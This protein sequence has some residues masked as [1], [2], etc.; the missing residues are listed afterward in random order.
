MT[1]IDLRLRPPLHGFLSMI[2]YANGPRRDRATRMHGFEPAPSAL[3][4]SMPLLLEEMDRGGVTMGVVV[5]RLSELYGSVS[6]DDVAR[7]LKEYPGR[8]IGV[9]S[10]DPAQ[11]E[12][13]ISEISRRL[14][15][16][17]RAVN[18]EPGV[19]AQPMFANDRRLYPIYEHCQSIGAPVIVMAGG[20][21]GPDLEYTNP[22]YLDRM[23][24]DFPD[25]KVV[26]SHGGW[27][28]VHQILSIAYRRPNVYVSPDQY[29]ANMPGMD[30]Y[31]RAADTFLADRFLYGSSYPFLPADTCA[32]WFRSLPIRPESMEKALFRNAA[33]LF[34]IEL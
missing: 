24:A 15:E 34:H 28:W 21:A 2:M 23:A 11:P 3:Q 27:P 13:S 31:V 6:N 33:K 30:D 8:F 22:V 14:A 18:I 29:L 20:G 9:A 12:A 25:L 19:Y 7:V 26:V 10:V 1:I 32:D 5:G 16:G 4:Q 17:F